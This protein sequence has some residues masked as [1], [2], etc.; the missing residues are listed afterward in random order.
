MFMASLVLQGSWYAALLA[1]LFDLLTKRYMKSTRKE[2]P[3]VPVAVAAGV[4]ACSLGQTASFP[5]ETIS[6]RMQVRVSACY[7]NHCFP[8]HAV[9]V[10]AV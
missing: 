1:G 5:L 7:M 9:P 8:C 6:R 3:G 10:K 4:I 2:K